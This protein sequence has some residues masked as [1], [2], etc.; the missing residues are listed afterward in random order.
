PNTHPPLF[1]GTAKSEKKTGID[2][3][4]WLQQFEMNI[5]EVKINIKFSEMIKILEMTLHNT[6][7]DR[8]IRLL[9]TLIILLKKKSNNDLKFE[10]VTPY[11]YNI[12]EEMLKQMFNHNYK[13]QRKMPKPYWLINEIKHSTDQIPDILIEKENELIIIDAKYYST[14]TG[15]VNKYPGWESIVKQLYYNLSLKDEYD[16]IK[17]IFCMPESMLEDFKYIGKTSVEGQEKQF[18]YVDA[19]SLDLNL[20]ISSYINNKKQN[21]L[22]NNIVKYIS[23]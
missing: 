20:V 13:L 8:E 3:F 4:G 7:K 2:N 18:G 12:W 22:L 15:S 9:K 16:I 11:F 10:M 19:F 21:D 23:T 14:Y 6:F 1:A 5:E 17:N